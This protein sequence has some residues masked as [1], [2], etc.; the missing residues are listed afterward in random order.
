MEQNRAFEN[1]EKWLPE[2]EDTEGVYGIPIIQPVR[3]VP[4]VQTWRRFCSLKSE[5]VNEQM[6]IHFFIQDY[7]FQ[8]VW[9]QPDKYVP[10]LQKAACVL[11]PDFSMYT[12]MPMAMQMYNHYRKHWLAAYWQMRG[13][14]VIPTIS[15]SDKSSHAW[16]FDGEPRG[17]V[18]AVSSVGS[19]RRADTRQLFL[20]GYRAMMDTIQPS[21]VLF[22]G[23]VPPECEGNIIP[24]QPDYNY[25]RNRRE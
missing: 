5:G 24:V 3:E 1:I 15:W 14:R 25:E 8:R 11:S 20:A 23:S 18:V 13:L 16:C 7:Q 12:D 17:G 19:Q 6:G 2:R 10:L 9:L 4:Q 22:W 21:A